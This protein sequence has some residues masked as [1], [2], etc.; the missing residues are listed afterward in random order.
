MPKWWSLGTGSAAASRDGVMPT[1]SS[2][3]A[4]SS[5]PKERKSTF[6]SNS[7]YILCCLGSAIGLGN[8][9][10]FPNHCYR[11]G[12][13]G[14]LLPYLF[15]VLLIGVPMLGAETMLGQMTQRSAVKAFSMIR[16]KLW[17]LGA[18]VTWAAFMVVSYYNVIMA[19]SLQYL[20]YSFQSPLPWGNTTASAKDFFFGTVLRMGGPDGAEVW[21]L[22]DGMGS[23]N[24]ALLL[25]LLAQWSL[26]FF[27]IF[28]LQKTAQWIVLITVPV[29]LVLIVVMVIYGLTKPGSS[30]GVMAYINPASNPGAILSLDAWVD[31][32]SQIFFG[33]SLSVGVMIAFSSHQPR[34]SKVVAN[35][36]IVAIG[37]SMTSIVAGF[38]VF[39]LLGHFASTSGVELDEVAS[40]GYIL[41]FQTFPA[42]FATFA[43]KGAPQAFSVIFFLTLILLGIDSA[44]SLVEAVCE[45][46]IDNNE[47]CR[48]HPPVVVFA[49]CFTGFLCSILMASKSGYYVLDILDHFSSAYLMLVGGALSAIVIGWLYPADKIVRQ[50]KNSANQDAFWLPFLWTYAIKFV[51]PAIL[52][53]LFLYNFVRDCMRPYNGYPQWA[54]V[55]FGWVPCLIIPVLAFAIP[56]FLFEKPSQAFACAGKIAKVMPRGQELT[57]VKG[58]MTTV[59]E[60]EEVVVGT[61]RSSV[62]HVDEV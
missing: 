49:F 1:T 43:G 31:A 13:F 20:F 32:S 8:M 7:Q 37:N 40:A 38:A 24:W 56:S 47:W 45:A 11:Y 39:A 53:L 14:F 30:Q 48:R 35:T 44:M 10:R 33:L 6:A 9:L 60:D 61:S 25:A 62:V 26:I 46:F 2:A 4:S 29:P 21:T 50:V 15:A 55:C 41:S 12:G 59:E 17:G 52:I 28:N 23:V 34:E 58:Q 57:G 19:W 3:A 54:L 51:T 22:D 16:P 42:T 5:M 27:C 18:L 36:W